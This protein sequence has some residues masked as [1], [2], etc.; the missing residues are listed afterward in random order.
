MGSVR[1][2]AGSQVKERLDAEGAATKAS[3]GLDR[4]NE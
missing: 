1:D 2:F 3:I 4:V